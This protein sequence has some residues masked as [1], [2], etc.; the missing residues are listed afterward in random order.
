MGPSP[1]LLRPVPRADAGPERA[2]GPSG[3]LTPERVVD[4][5]VAL[6]DERGADALSLSAVARELGVRTP[7]LYHH[8]AGLDGLRRAVRLHG[9]ERLGDVLQ[10]AASGRSGRDALTAVAQAYRTFGREHPGLYALT[11][12]GRYEDDRLAAAAG[13]VVDTVLAV[14]RGYGLDGEEALHATRYLR[15]AL[16]GFV[17]LEQQGG[18]GMP[19]DRETSFEHLVDATDAGLRRLSD[20]TTQRSSGA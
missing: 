4:A 20:R 14:L 7:S 2:T 16:H 9:L 8:V 12:V 15:S 6:L 11:L 19:I 3:R 10:R 1:T 17:A 5:A 13:R 18:F